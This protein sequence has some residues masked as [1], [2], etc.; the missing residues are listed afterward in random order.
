MSNEIK[1][2][3]STTKFS[4]IKNIIWIIKLIWKIRKSYIIIELTISLINAILP[5]ALAWCSAL[6]I[7]K[8]TAGEYKSVFDPEL[9]LI[10]LAYISLPFVI[11]SLKV[12]YAYVLNQFS[13][14]FEQYIELSL[15][16]KKGEIDIQT[17]ESQEFHNLLL[18]ANENIGRLMHFSD[19]VSYIT[20]K[21]IQI[22]IAV[23]IM[24]SYKWW[25]TIMLFL[26]MLPHLLIE[27][28]FGQLKWSIW[29]C[30]AETKRKFS[31]I[32]RHF[33]ILGSL[34]EIK[35][36]NLKTYF[37][38]STDQLL[39]EFNEE[40][41][42]NEKK[43]FWLKLSAAFTEHAA[44]AFLV[45]YL[46]SDVIDKNIEINIF[47]FLISRIVSFRIDLNEFFRSLSNLNTDSLFISDIRKLIST[48]KVIRNGSRKLKPHTPTIEFRNVSFSYPGTDTSVLENFNF[49]IKAGDKVAVVGINGA[50][51]TTLIKALMRFYDCKSGEILIDGTP[52]KE[53]DLA[54]FY[55]QVAYL[56]Q[57]FP[58][59]RLPVKQAIAL[60]RG[61]EPIDEARV[62][63]CAKR[64][65]I[66]E[67]ILGWKDGYNSYL[68]KEFNGAEPSVGQWQKLALARALYRNAKVLIL[69]EPTSSID[70]VAEM[71]IFEEL[72]KL[73]NDVT[74]IMISHRFNTVKDCDTIIVI[75][76]N[77]IKEMGNHAELMSIESGTYQNLFNTQKDSYETQATGE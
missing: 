56:A 1:N 51:K 37:T 60:G 27:I 68:G 39:T 15:I 41:R 77:Q 38:K 20:G 47:I 23:F 7:K 13:V 9:L 64:A 67:T 72:N 17:H 22:S 61:D 40:I 29:D 5:V 44:E 36:S 4:L 69:D 52:I 46:M 16:D 19:F 42:S 33:S 43:R 74:V 54:T 73:P 66:H 18:K 76:N 25:V 28:R 6:F 48:P 32:K 71:A 34:T 11:G 58:R 24:L 35:V 62:V 2:K 21:V 75:E 49:K 50:G 14:F 53:L 10:F 31:E 12:I 65:G 26:A 55:S 59:F 30:K 63:D 8:I 3:E 45:F 57:E 70:A